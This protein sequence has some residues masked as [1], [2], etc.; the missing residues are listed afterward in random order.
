MKRVWI[1]EAVSCCNCHRFQG[2][3][4]SL[5]VLKM[6]LWS[7][8]VCFSSMAFL[9]LWEAW[10]DGPVGVCDGSPCPGESPAV[11]VSPVPQ[12]PTSLCDQQHCPHSSPRH[13]WA[14]LFLLSYSGLW[15]GNFIPSCLQIKLSFQESFSKRE[16]A[17]YG[18]PEENRWAGDTQEGLG[19]MDQHWNQQRTWCRL[20]EPA[21]ALERFSS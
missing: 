21:R 2:G 12:I 18:F 4:T 17:P 16:A 7:C 8:A 6:H 15:E 14:V 13:W 5:E 3:K 10:M 1:P 11:K 20:I 19:K 9:L